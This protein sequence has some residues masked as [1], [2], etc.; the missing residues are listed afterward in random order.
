MT[1]KGLK[2]C[3]YQLQELVLGALNQSIAGKLVKSVNI[4]RDSYTG[5]IKDVFI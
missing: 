3:T 5:I 1:H 2:I 4:L